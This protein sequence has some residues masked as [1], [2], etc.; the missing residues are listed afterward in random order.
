MES[1]PLDEVQWRSPEWIQQNNGLRTDNVLEYF[2]YS[3]FYDRGSNNQILKMQS[4]FQQPPAAAAPGVPPHQAA[5]Q[6]QQQ[7]YAELRN[8]KGTEFVVAIAREPELWIIRKQTR[9]SPQETRP[10]ATYFVVGENIYMAPSV[11][12]VVSSRLL[13]TT[14]ALTKALA[15]ASRLHGFSPSQGYFYKNDLAVAGYSSSTNGSSSHNNN[16]GSNAG[17]I[18]SRQV[19]PGT[20][21]A[22]STSTSTGGS[23]GT[24]ASTALL[25]T[26]MER[27]AF[28]A[29]DR[30]LSFTMGGAPSYID[31]VP[32][33]SASGS[34]NGGSSNGVN[35]AAA[36]NAANGPAAAASGG[37]GPGTGVNTA[38][39][40]PVSTPASVITNSTKPNP[41]RRKKLH[42]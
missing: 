4:Q 13:S 22:A 19:T 24:H 6:Q 18:V 26:N 12:S 36:G 11:H 3:P 27:I 28:S 29:I 38:V 9:L 25:T 42:G 1:E 14:Q 32:D 30:A 16:N 23:A 7:L 37:G 41:R 33:S 2:S 15:K 10:L 35:P 21:P 5:Q 40:T 34:G 8:M 31:D 39:A 20:T 17:R